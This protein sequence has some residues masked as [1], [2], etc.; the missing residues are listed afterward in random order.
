MLIKT[1]VENTSIAED[2]GHEHG[3]SLYIESKNYKI[4]FDTGAG[5]LF[6]ENAK[7]MGVDLG[8]VD[9]LVLS[10]GHYDHGGGLETFFQVNDMAKAYIH[11]DAFKGHY[12]LR[13]TGN[14][15]YI[16]LEPKLKENKQIVFTSDDFC[17]DKGLTLFS[18]VGLKEP[19]PKS[20][21]GLFQDMDGQMI[22][23][24]FSHEQNLII[25]EDG[26][27]ILLT[28]CAHMGLINILD[29]FKAIKGRMP[30]YLIGGFHLAGRSGSSED[31][32]SLARLGHYL[33]NTGARFYTGHC[34]GLEAYESL[35]S[36]MG[37]RISY[38]ATGSVIRI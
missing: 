24:N 25:E 36:L 33:L 5:G 32:E 3:L 16:G 17:I 14:I 18:N 19:G 2:L 7:K 38:L 26:K 34:T 23:D 4:L 29:H 35:K 31:G 37:N 15:E 9:F 21:Q 27:L 8:Q 1:L 10:H 20:N 28:G 12:A 13:S 6:L 22:E 11:Q 30:D